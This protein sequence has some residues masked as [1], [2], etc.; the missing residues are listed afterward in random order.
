MNGRFRVALGTV[1]GLLL[2]VAAAGT[3]SASTDNDWRGGPQRDPFVHRA[4]SSL[5]LA[6]RP[7][8]F[9]GSNNYYL[10]YAAQSSVDDIFDRSGAAGFT[11]LRSWAF[12]DIG[13]QDGSNSVHGKQNGIYFQY[14]DG[15]QPAYNDGADG[16]AH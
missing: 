15:T 8:R 5:S 10:M 9:A 13:N 1:A 3:A 12:L 6:G 4:D 7:F 2:A 11:V 14:W 16:L